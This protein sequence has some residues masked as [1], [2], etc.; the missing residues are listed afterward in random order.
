GIVAMSVTGVGCSAF[1]LI[2]PEFD[3]SS[4][5]ETSVKLSMPK[6]NGD[7]PI[8]TAAVTVGGGPE[9]PLLVD[10]GSPGVRVFASQVGSDVT[11]TDIPVDVTFADGTRFIGIEASAPI[12]FGGLTTKGPITVQLITEVGCAEGKP[13]CVGAVGLEKFAAEQPFDGLFG[14]GLQAASIYSPLS[15][16]ANGSPATFSVTADPGKASGAITFNQRPT[17]PAAT[18]DMP[19][20]A[21]PRMPN[22]YPA[23]A[24]NQAQGCWSYGGQPAQC[25]PTAFDTGSP[26]LFTDTSVPGVPTALGPVPTDTTIALAATAGGAPVWSVRAGSTPGRNTVAVAPLDGGN[27]VNSG[28]SLFRAKLVTFDAEHGK[29]LITDP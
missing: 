12:S 4:L 9:V 5:N 10:T 6:V 21:Q 18:F 29:V 22:G 26:T 2:T 28:I 7:R 1:S 8:L 11:R 16:L 3:T 27:N 19:A 23:W 15:Q 17:A 14:I 20:W 13:T 24:S 25:L